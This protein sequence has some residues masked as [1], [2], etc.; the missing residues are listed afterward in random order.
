M[1]VPKALGLHGLGGCE[2]VLQEGHAKVGLTG[3]AGIRGT[4]WEKW[5]ESS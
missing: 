4:T 1:L 2:P 5:G 3:E